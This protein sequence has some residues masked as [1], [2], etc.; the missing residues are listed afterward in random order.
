MRAMKQTVQKK[1]KITA[2]I[3][4]IICIM[5]FSVPVQAKTT[6]ISKVMNKKVSSAAS[7]LGLK[8][9]YHKDT[10]S[11]IY[12]YNGYKNSTL[13]TY[14]AKGKY[15]SSRSYIQGESY[16]KNKAGRWNAYIKDK[17]LSIYGVKVGMTTSQAHKKFIKYKWR[18]VWNSSTGCTYVK[19]SKVISVTTRSGRI[20]TMTYLWQMESE[21]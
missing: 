16:Y 2:G 1:K 20:K 8:R 12:F 7:A 18:R 17:S 14:A 9:D 19:G 10:K 11:R 6:D 15:S 13:M 21:Y 4:L 5:L 3:L